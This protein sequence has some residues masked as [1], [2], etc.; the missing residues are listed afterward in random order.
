MLFDDGTKIIKIHTRERWEIPRTDEGE[1]VMTC[2]SGYIIEIIKSEGKFPPSTIN[3]SIDRGYKDINYYT[4]DEEWVFYYTT[5]S[6][7]F[8]GG[9]Q[10]SIENFP[11]KLR[12]IK[13]R[14]INGTKD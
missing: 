11:S 14:E 12:E 13:L 9:G 1:L 6:S 7:S 2:K 5:F 8:I 3:I 4:K 10:I